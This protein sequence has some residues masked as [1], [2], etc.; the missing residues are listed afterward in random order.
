MH[1][2]QSADI[3]INGKIAGFLSKVHPNITEDFDIPETFIAEIAFDDLLPKHI[4]A[5]AIS[6]FQGV[7][8]D[9]SLVIDKNLSYTHIDTI[10]KGLDLPLL[11]KNYPI[12]VYEDETLINEKSLTLRLFIQ[13]LEKTLDDEDIESTVNTIINKL[14]SEYGARLR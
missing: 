4:N 3:I 5:H 10:I 7:Y 14:E 8:K 11:S 13:S 2:Y 12:D 9:L 6:K 1:P